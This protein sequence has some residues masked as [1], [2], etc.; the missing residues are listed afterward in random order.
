MQEEFL[1]EKDFEIL[2]EAHKLIGLM[3]ETLNAPDFKTNKTCQL[4]FLCQAMFLGDILNPHSIYNEHIS[5]AA[6]GYAHKKRVSLPCKT[7]TEIRNALM[8]NCF[9]EI[10]CEVLLRTRQDLE[11]FQSKIIVLFSIVK[12]DP[13]AKPITSE[14]T[15]TYINN[16]ATDVE[17]SRS[18]WKNAIKFCDEFY[19]WIGATHES[20]QNTTWDTMNDLHCSIII[21][22]SYIDNESI[23]KENVINSQT[24]YAQCYLLIKAGQAA[25]NLMQSFQYA[26]NNNLKTF[27]MLRGD[28]IHEQRKKPNHD[29]IND[30]CNKLLGINNLAIANLK[31][32]SN[33]EWANQLIITVEG[34]CRIDLSFTDTENLFAFSE[35]EA[36]SNE[37]ILFNEY[38]GILY[39]DSESGNYQSYSDITT[40][41]RKWFYDHSL[42]LKNNL[43]VELRRQR[44]I[45][46]NEQLKWV[47]IDFNTKIDTLNQINGICQGQIIAWRNRALNKFFILKEE[48]NGLK[49]CEDFDNIYEKMRVL[50]EEQQI[51]FGKNIYFL[52]SSD[53][54]YIE[55]F[56]KEYN[57]RYYMD[58]LSLLENT[59]FELINMTDIKPQSYNII[60]NQ[61]KQVNEKYAYLFSQK[62]AGYS[63]LTEDKINF[64]LSELLA[65]CQLFQERLNDTSNMLLNNQMSKTG[66]STSQA[67]ENNE[68]KR[69][70]DDDKVENTEGDKTKKDDKN[71]EDDEN[72]DSQKK[73]KL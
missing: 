49:T 24:L 67:P 10:D 21:C 4:A 44:S 68:K 31:S 64:R 20:I 18:P 14:A 57:R 54:I 8:Y 52:I 70:R 6:L 11:I 30:W 66:E 35:A 22:E 33:N 69:N 16:Q 51:N 17:L 53:K 61:L 55:N 7:T 59:I 39:P 63:F 45:L 50:S 37:L 23:K 41:V 48:F 26:N 28:L 25:R 38:L 5:S 43:S 62:D 42:E 71:N 12:L 60:E 3:I 19:S 40:D 65:K 72:D 58:Y 2:E 13:E 34:I 36:N 47:E 32:S 56:W 29:E 1:K 73:M 46:S 27:N 9:R 15:N